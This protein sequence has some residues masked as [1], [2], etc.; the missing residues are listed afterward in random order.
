[1]FDYLNFQA[2]CPVC[3]REISGDWQ[4]K[5]GLKLTQLVDF[6]EVN[7]FYARCRHCSTL[8]EYTR[9]SAGSIEDYERHNRPSGG[10]V[11]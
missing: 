6:R 8:V 10:Y 3:G 4:T 2:P 9:R 7:R 11:A 5:D 1:M